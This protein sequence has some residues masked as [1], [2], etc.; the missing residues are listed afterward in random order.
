[1]SRQLLENEGDEHPDLRNAGHIAFKVKTAPHPL[2]TRVLPLA[3]VSRVCA[4]VCVY[5][6][7]CACVHVH[8]RVRVRARVIVL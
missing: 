1:M 3:F 7:M 5:V 2:F 8:V 4:C 6:C